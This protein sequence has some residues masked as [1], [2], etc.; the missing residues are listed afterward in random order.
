[1]VC[2]LCSKAII[3][4]RTQQGKPNKSNLN[5]TTTEETFLTVVPESYRGHLLSLSSLSLEDEICSNSTTASLPT[6]SSE[7]QRKK[8]PVLRKFDKFELLCS[9][10]VC[11]NCTALFIREVTILISLFESYVYRIIIQPVKLVL[12]LKPFQTPHNCTCPNQR[13]SLFQNSL[14]IKIC[15]TSFTALPHVKHDRGAVQCK[16]TL[17]ICISDHHFHER[18]FGRTYLHLRTLFLFHVLRRC[19]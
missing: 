15:L 17:T 18:I 10:T 16:E 7:P 19:V 13:I 6:V 4:N 8:I 12:D 9:K 1:M 2:R 3:R 5:P 11:V 14:Y